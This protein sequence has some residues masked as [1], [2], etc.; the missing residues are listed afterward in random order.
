M[1][2]P[3]DG[4]DVA[5][6]IPLRRRDRDLNAAPPVRE[7]LPRERAAFDPELE[8]GDVILKRRS[9]RR[10]MARLSEVARRRTTLGLPRARI[11]ATG[12]GVAVLA[13]SLAVAAA[14]AVAVI[15]SP[16][17]KNPNPRA[18]SIGTSHRPTQVGKVPT[19]TVAKHAASI[20]SSP[21]EHPRAAVHHRARTRA[22]VH[23]ARN[24]SSSDS[25]SGPAH[26][27]TSIPVS[28]PAPAQST[29]TYTT[30]A[31]P[32]H[33]TSSSSSGSGSGSSSGSSSSTPSKAALKS[34][35]TGAGTCSCQ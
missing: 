34:L 31:S 15:E 27:T 30:S 12:P 11:L 33:Y 22:S 20:R 26:P 18:Q 3:T 32:P 10:L 7:P 5:R 29:P 2:P 4:E 35:V 23:H 17:A 16:G 6:V 24:R 8:P 9:R 14:A 21:R 13:A 19:D 25:G 1:D 28:N